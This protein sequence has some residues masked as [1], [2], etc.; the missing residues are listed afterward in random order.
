MTTKAQAKVPTKASSDALLRKAF[1][2]CERKDKASAERFFNAAIE[3]YRA[4]GRPGN[5]NI[6]AS[7]RDHY[8]SQI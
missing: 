8:L 6:T 2:A 7:D 1:K 4:C 5:A 3:G